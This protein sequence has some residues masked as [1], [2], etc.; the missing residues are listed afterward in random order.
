MKSVSKTSARLERLVNLLP[1]GV[2]IEF[3]DYHRDE[4]T[5]DLHE[6][7]QEMKWLQRFPFLENLSL[8]ASEENNFV[9]SSG[10][11]HLEKEFKRTQQLSIPYITSHKLQKNK[12]LLPLGYAAPLAFPE[13][14]PPAMP[15]Y[16]YSSLAVF[17]EG[18]WVF[19]DRDYT[20]SEDFWKNF[21]NIP[22]LQEKEKF[23]WGIII[24]K[25]K[26]PHPIGI[27]REF[28]FHLGYNDK[29]LPRFLN[30]SLSSLCNIHC[31]ICG[32]QKY[33]KEHG[34]K[35]NTIDTDFLNKIAKVF[36]PYVNTVELNSF[37]E[38]LLH[39]DFHIAIELLNK[40]ECNFRLQTNGTFL[41]ELKLQAILKG[42]GEVSFSID[43]TGE[44]FEA[45]RVGAKWETV[46]NNVLRLLAKRDPQR[47]IVSLYPTITRKT[48]PCVLDL[49]R[50]A[51]DA[52]IDFVAL[53][54]YNPIAGGQEE[55]PTALEQKNLLT[56]LKN[57]Y[58]T[59]KNP[60]VIT[61]EGHPV[62]KNQEV[63]NNKKI[64]FS[65]Y[66]SLIRYT[67]RPYLPRAHSGPHAEYVCL[68]PLIMG[69]IMPN[70]IF[71]P[72]CTKMHQRTFPCPT[73]DQ[74]FFSLWFGPELTN[75]RNSLSYHTPRPS[76][77]PECKKCIADR[78]RSIAIKH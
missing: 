20:S 77:L 44:I 61:L 12:V 28:S 41:T 63:Y 18:E 25:D 7:I 72:G 57:H 54:Y 10:K 65:K 76:L 74:E 16:M 39:K 5:G 11:A 55:R 78:A 6:T 40:Y 13:G 21:K 71:F 1:T 50:W 60:I 68:D 64:L 53:H 24:L 70:E 62:T 37:G 23:F 67:Y 43:A 9:H 42:H 46:E 30:L 4:S 49:C 73:T 51:E 45:Q 33:Y 47:I 38:Q 2:N 36:F 27:S 32:T 56:I 75:I 58:R 69:N 19:F 48:L 22:N 34:I 52:G 31:T 26:L 14:L 66:P 15:D 59:S 35:G 3:F 17:H 8:L 29:P